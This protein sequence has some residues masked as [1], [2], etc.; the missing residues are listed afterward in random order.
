[1]HR[2][3]RVGPFQKDGLMNPFAAQCDDFYL[4]CYLNTELEMPRS[5]DTILHFFEQISKAYPSMTNFYGREANEYVLEEDKDLGSYRWVSLETQRAA[6]GYLNPPTLEACHP[7]HE[8]MLDLA[9]PILSVGSLDCEAIDVMF[10]FDFAFKGN[11][12]DVVSEAFARDT[13]LDSFLNVP[14]GKVVEFEPSITIA[15]DEQCKTQARLGVVTRTN[16]Y[17]V[18]TGQY[19]EDVISIYFTV[20][21]YWGM[22]SDGTFVASYRRQ[23][24]Q[25]LELVHEHVVPNI[26]VPLSEVISTR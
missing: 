8:L 2:C 6:S 20:R 26:L 17:Q 10:G 24:E 7:Q 15:L 22:G 14:G 1:M 4:T 11:H 16:S 21:R 12:D 9:Q 5:R 13:R 19:G 3:R 25:G 23:V 18:R